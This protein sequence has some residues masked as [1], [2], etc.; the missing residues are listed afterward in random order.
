MP[1]LVIIFVLIASCSFTRAQDSPN[2]GE[3]LSAGELSAWDINIAPDGRGLPDGEGSV[4]QGRDV[5]VNLCQDCHG[6]NGRGGPDDALAGY[7]DLREKR[8][9]GNYWPCATTLFDYIRRAMPLPNTQSLSA[10]ELYAVSAYILYLNGLV[11]A[12]AIMNAD[13]LP[14]VRMPNRDQF[15]SDYGPPPCG[16]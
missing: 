11:A 12:D 6:E 5:Y 1:N 14:Q 16:P 9:V 15:Y 2:L 3:P 7:A 4:A 10:E 8:T 13:S